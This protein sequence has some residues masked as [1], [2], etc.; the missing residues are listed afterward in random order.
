MFRL[1]QVGP[2]SQDS[3]RKYYVH[4]DDEYT[5]YSFIT[6]VLTISKEWGNVRLKRNDGVLKSLMLKYKCGEIQ[7]SNIPSD[8]LKSKIVGAVCYGGYT[9]ADYILELPDI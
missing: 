4:L 9:R 3:T 2:I 8:L 5:V 6:T 1:E 7:S